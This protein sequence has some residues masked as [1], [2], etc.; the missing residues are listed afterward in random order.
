M[1]NFAHALDKVE[2]VGAARIFENMSIARTAA[3][4]RARRIVARRRKASK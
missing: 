4:T 1:L 2:V 3:P